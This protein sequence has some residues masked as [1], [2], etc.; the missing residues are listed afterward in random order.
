MYIVCTL[1]QLYSRT[2]SIQF[3]F[4]LFHYSFVGMSDS[5]HINGRMSPEAIMSRGSGGNFTDGGGGSEEAPPPLP[6]KKKK[7]QQHHQ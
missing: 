7:K 4:V 6:I 1:C 3:L 5:I 2:T